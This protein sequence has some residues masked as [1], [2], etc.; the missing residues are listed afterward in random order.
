MDTSIINIGITMGD[1]AGI[2][3]EVLV[4]SL[5]AIPLHEKVRFLVFGDLDILSREAK[6][7]SLSI[8]FSIFKKP[9]DRLDPDSVNVCSLTNLKPEDCSY[10]NSTKDCANAAMTYV[11][12][13]IN[14][15]KDGLLDGFITAPVSKNSIRRIVTNFTGHT[16]YIA[17][18][19]R[20]SNPVMLMVT[21]KLKVVPL[22]TH[23]TV[24]DAVKNLSSTL[25]VDT[26]KTINAYIPSY[27]GIKSPRIAVSG[28][29]PHAGEDVFG[30]EE[31][32]IIKPAIAK[33]NKLE[34]KV[35][36]PFAP[37][38]VFLKGLNGSYDVILA[39]YHDQALIPV[40]TMFFEQVVNVTLGLPFIRTSPGHGVAFDIAGRNI[41]KHESMLAAILQTVSMAKERQNIND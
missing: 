8:D 17:S 3:P 21:P 29:N 26:L 6:K 34:M 9:G 13:A 19:V 16:E 14:L 1:P 39:M 25:I 11:D 38:S 23:I 32:D 10:G 7:A 12:S 36:G 5:A 24:I 30:T 37:D 15:A 18:K 22:T 40:K 35:D 31:D 27:F 2:G 4:K 41:A 33:A 28:L 20:V